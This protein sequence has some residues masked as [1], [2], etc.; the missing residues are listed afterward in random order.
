MRRSWIEVCRSARVDLL[1]SQPP[2]GLQKPA[3]SKV[4]FESENSRVPVNP[5]VVV[6]SELKIWV[7]YPLFVRDA[8]WVTAVKP[9]EVEIECQQLV[10]VRSIAQVKVGLPQIVL[11]VITLPVCSHVPGIKSKFQRTHRFLNH[12]VGRVIS[13]T[14]TNLFGIEIPCEPGA[15]YFVIKF[16]T[17]AGSGPRKADCCPRE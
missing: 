14:A 4:T 12:I 6:W 17:G 1:M 5:V 3:L 10:L 15:G 2:L 9:A 11:A 7:V 8:S 13:I 16:P